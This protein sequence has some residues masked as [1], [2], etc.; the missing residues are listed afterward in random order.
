M[1][2]AA[3][4]RMF[5][6]PSGSDSV[7]DD[8]AEVV[9]TVEDVRVGAGLLSNGCVCCILIVAFGIAAF[10]PSGGSVM[11]AVSFLGDAA[12]CTI[13]SAAAPALAAAVATGAPGG[14]A[15]GLP[16]EVGF[17]GT[18]GRAPSDG[19]FGGGAMPPTG[20]T[21]GSGA[22]GADGG[23]GGG[24]TK[25]RAMEDGGGGALG[26]GVAGA[27]DVGIPASVSIFVVSFF[28]DTPAGGSG[29][30]EAGFPGRL[31]RTVS[32][33]TG[34]CSDLAGSVMRMVSALEASSSGVGGVSSG[35]LIE[36]LLIRLRRCQSDCPA[37]FGETVRCPKNAQEPR[38]ELL[39]TGTLPCWDF[40]RWDSVSR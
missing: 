2:S 26:A 31:M 11:R 27:E 13:G 39:E 33:L 38:T 20:L 19:G 24:G 16:G 3:M 32:R 9:A 6:V 4:L 37:R 40:R 22:P 36:V 30:V 12:F 15:A 34:P 5:T 7:A 21:G 25:G 14:R 1:T 17:S 35:I 10:A 18:V 29:A 23:R 8:V 28:G